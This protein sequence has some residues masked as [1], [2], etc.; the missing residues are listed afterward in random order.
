MES[1]ILH[2]DHIKKSRIRLID[3]NKIR[4]FE[5]REKYNKNPKRCK[6]CN[7]I[8]SYEKRKN[9]FCDHSCSASFVN[10]DIQRNYCSGKYI[11]KMC[12]VC[13]TV[14]KNE[15]FCSQKCFKKFEWDSIKKEIEVTGKISGL[16]TGKKYLKE[17]NGNKCSI[18][19]LSEWNGK[20][21]VLIMDH[22]DG[23][24]DNEF[25]NNLRLICPNC[26]SQLP[27][28]KGRNKGNGRHNRRKRYSEGK[29]Y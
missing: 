29:S 1:E 19:G 3:M 16:S 24:S 8:L 10:R 13:G 18:C 12:I 25:I 5:K 17:I 20:E 15:K 6:F 23:K 2:E 7:N 28:Y 14:T 9:K 26:D 4:S 11:K 22:I 21:I 27:T